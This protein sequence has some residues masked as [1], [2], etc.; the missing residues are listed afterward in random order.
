MMG[1]YVEIKAYGE[2]A[3]Q[4]LEAVF[5]RLAAIEARMTLAS[6]ESEIVR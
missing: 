5:S 1:T 6:E 3:P 4:A 2:K